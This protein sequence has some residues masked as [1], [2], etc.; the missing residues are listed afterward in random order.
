MKYRTEK[1]SFGEV[2][3]PA[4]K[5]WGASTQ[6]AIENFKIGHEEMPWKLIHALLLQKKACAEVN[7]EMGSI[8]TEIGN[9]IIKAVDI[10]LKGEMKDNFPL[11]VWQTGSGTGSNMNANEVIANVANELLG[12][13]KGTKHPVHPNDHV[14]YGQSSNDTFPTAMHIATVITTEQ[15]LIPALNRFH[16]ELDKKAKEWKDIVKLGRTHL[17]DATPITLGQEFSGYAQQVK[18]ALERINNS[19]PYVKMLAQGGTAVGTG[20]NSK[21]GFDAKFA[22]AISQ[23]TDIN[24]VTAPNKFEALAANDALLELSGTL[25][26]IAA[27]V[28]KIAND[29]RLLGS[30]PRCGLGE[31]ILPS[32]EPGSSIMP[33]KVNPTQSESL[34]MVAAQIMGNHTAIT[35]G[36]ATGHLELNV[37][38]P[39]I[40]YNIL[41]SIELLAT[42]CLSFTDKCLS[43][44]KPNL[45]R[46]EKLRDESLMLVTALNPHIGY[47][48]AASIAKYAYEN[49]IGLQQASEDLGILTAEEFKKHVVPSDMVSP[50]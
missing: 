34:T 1:D 40:I 37:F 24:F 6:R 16:V 29:I 17:Q 13:E 11:V 26:V 38:R 21:L 42:G 36:G 43:G 23:I 44:I 4:N 2:K 49:N 27:S 47:D 19:L 39:M 15:E 46:I 33:G 25:N 32:N 18:F 3:V 31:L 48:K 9:V 35:I 14:N 7:M 22:Q 45:E 10:L 41:Q 5:Y 28:M 50:K 8:P 12:F 20:I 30:G